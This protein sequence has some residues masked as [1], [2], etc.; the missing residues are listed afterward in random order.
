M[1]DQT[2]KQYRDQ[3]EIGHRYHLE[4]LAAQREAE[5]RWA[6]AQGLAAHARAIGEAELIKTRAAHHE[7]EMALQR[8]RMWRVVT[9]IITGTCCTALLLL[10]WRAYP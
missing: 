10:L 8:I 3:Q 4:H 7:T 5:A 9:A 6:E 2:Y 1:D